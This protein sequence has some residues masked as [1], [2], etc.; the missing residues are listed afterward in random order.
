MKMF[1]NNSSSVFMEES[2]FI[3]KWGDLLD[4]KKEIPPSDRYN[5]AVPFSFMCGKRN[6]R[7][8]LNLKDLRRKSGEWLDKKRVSVLTWT[9]KEA[10]I[11]CE[12]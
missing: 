2:D 5:E 8:W 3:R 11:R 7:D 9:D 12:M 10:S 1:N 4:G 6:S